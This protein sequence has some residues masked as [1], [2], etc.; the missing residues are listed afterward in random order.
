MHNSS[1]HSPF[2]V[3]APFRSTSC[4]TH[5]AHVSGQRIRL[6][7]LCIDN[8]GKYLFTYPIPIKGVYA[9]KPRSFSSDLSQ[10]QHFLDIPKYRI[11]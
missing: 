3:A 8:L 1:R 6:P 4:P 5:Q 9:N 11:Y 10:P 7:Y 2:S